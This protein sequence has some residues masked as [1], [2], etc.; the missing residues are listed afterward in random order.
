MPF[1]LKTKMVINCD[2]GFLNLICDIHLYIYFYFIFLKKV[3]RSDMPLELNYDYNPKDS[4]TE[5]QPTTRTG[6]AKFQPSINVHWA[7]SSTKML[8]NQMQQSNIEMTNNRNSI[9]THSNTNAARSPNSIISSHQE[10]MAAQMQRIRQLTLDQIELKKEMEQLEIRLQSTIQQNEPTETIQQELNQ[11]QFRWRMQQTE[12]QRLYRI[13]LE[14]QRQQLEEEERTF[15]GDADRLQQLAERRRHWELLWKQFQQRQLRE[16][17]VNG[18]PS[19]GY[20]VSS[21]PMAPRNFTQSAQSTVITS[22]QDGRPTR[23][24]HVQINNNGKHHEWRRTT[25]PQTVERLRTESPNQ[26]YQEKR[27]SFQSSASSSS[28]SSSSTS[29]LSSSSSSLSSSSSDEHLPTKYTSFHQEDCEEREQREEF[30]AREDKRQI[31]EQ[32]RIFRS[33]QN[34]LKMQQKRQFE[35]IR[36]LIEAR[37]QFKLPLNDCDHNHECDCNEN[38]TTTTMSTV[39]HSSTKSVYGKPYQENLEPTV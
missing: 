22:I 17:N 37:P 16:N 18:L 15:V 39:R 8:S 24:E 3:I 29:S 4:I 6:Q 11:C 30:L 5:R 14:Y 27:N 28:S 12:L 20:S 31:N 33:H 7:Q 38:S 35:E 13:Q 9:S 34:L 19:D 23:T 10:K 36:R 26:W 32:I 1:R 25:H 21:Q 2:S